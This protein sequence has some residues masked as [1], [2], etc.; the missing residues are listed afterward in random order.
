DV[1]E[2]EA[3]AEAL[4][5]R[6]DAADDVLERLL[7]P[8][9]REEVVQVPSVDPG[10]AEMVGEPGRIEA[11][12]ERA[13]AAE[14]VD[15]ER[16]GA[17]DRQRHPVQ[18]DR[19]VASHALED[20]ERAPAR[21]HEVLGERLEPVDPR[22]ALRDLVEVTRPEPDAASEEGPGRSAHD[23]PREAVLPAG[24]PGT[25]RVARGARPATV[26]A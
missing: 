19:E 20:R 3:A 26:T 12:G 21:R 24:A 22:A 1:L 9:Q 5:R 2:D 23:V 4:L 7:G 11:I 10:P 16:V 18:R 15:V 6:D 8:R 25:A 13:D 17:A 14:V